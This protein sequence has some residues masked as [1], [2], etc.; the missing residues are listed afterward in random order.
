[1][2]STTHLREIFAAPALSWLPDRLVKRIRSG[3]ALDRPLALGKV[4]LEQRRAIDDLLGRGSTGGDSVTLTPNRLCEALG[5]SSLETLMQACRPEVYEEIARRDAHLRT[6]SDVFETGRELTSCDA[7]WLAKLE[8]E[9]LLKRLSADNPAAAEILLR[10]AIAVLKSLP[11]DTQLLADLAA[12]VTGDSHALDRGQPLATLCLRAIREHH[13]IDGLRNAA[14]RRR[15]WAAAGVLCDDLSAPVLALNLT[16]SA[17]SPFA[18]ILA[19]HRRDGLPVFLPLRHL[20]DISFSPLPPSMREIFICENPNLLGRAATELGSAC[21]PLICTNGQPASAAMLLLRRLREAG[22][23]LRIHVDFDWAGLRIADQ[24]VRETAA[25]PWRMDAAIY[26]SS[27]ATVALR[28]KSFHPAWAGDLAAAMEKRGLAVFEE[29][30][31]A[32]LIAELKRG[33]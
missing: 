24:L 20:A 14:S 32:P 17:G 31:A 4:T 3:Q 25:L 1:M 2:K 28:G 26:Q 23:I 16:A 10:S 33:K 5:I 21:A 22:A 7:T 9:G 8:S 11:A 29:Q 15:A 27:P 19:L 30:V 12:T 13:G 18:N 6:W